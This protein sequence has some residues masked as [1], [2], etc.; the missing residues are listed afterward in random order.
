M[1]N[2][3]LLFSLII[4]FLSH[5]LFLMVFARPSIARTIRKAFIVGLALNVTA[6]GPAY[7]VMQSL[8]RLVR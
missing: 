3:I 2:W 1:A 7:T 8:V 4:Y 6:L 5:A